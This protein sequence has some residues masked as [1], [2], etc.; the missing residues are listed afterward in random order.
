M[1]GDEEPFSWCSHGLKPE[2]L[3]GALAGLVLILFVPALL[4]PYR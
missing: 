2:G 4:Q 1:V 3:G